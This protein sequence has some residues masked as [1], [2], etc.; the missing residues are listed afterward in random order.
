MG[1]IR[2]QI[3]FVPLHSTVYMS[4]LNQMSKDK[5]SKSERYFPFSSAL[6]EKT[7]KEADRGLMDFPLKKHY[8]KLRNSC[9]GQ[10]A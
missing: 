3:L 9:A 1:F 2:S 5:E 10:E 6:N 4:L 8:Y 7:V